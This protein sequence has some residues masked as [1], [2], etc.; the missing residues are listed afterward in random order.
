M[1]PQNLLCLENMQFDF[2]LYLLE[3]FLLSL[4]LMISKEVLRGREGGTPA[5]T[6]CAAGVAGPGWAGR[7]EGQI[8]RHKLV[9]L[10]VGPDGQRGLA[11]KAGRQV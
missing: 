2:E 7:L 6:L 4:R 11:L 5:Q 3:F 9:V 1:T 8:T 10:L